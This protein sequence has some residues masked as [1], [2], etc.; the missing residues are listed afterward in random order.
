MQETTYNI[1][2]TELTT[3]YVNEELYG[4]NKNSY[5]IAA[6]GPTVLEDK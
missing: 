6:L 4:T 3:W 5:T 1:D 2:G